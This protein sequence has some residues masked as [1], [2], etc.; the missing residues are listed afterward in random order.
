M[1][2]SGG[3]ASTAI[4]HG[5]RVTLQRISGHR[6]G[7]T[8]ACPGNAL[9]AQL[10]ELRRRAAGLAGPAAQQPPAGDARRRRRL[11]SPTARRAFSGVR[12]PG[13]RRGGSGRRRRGP[14]A[15]PGRLG[16]DRTDDDGRHGRLGRARPLAADRR[17]PRRGRG[18][19]LRLDG[20]HG[21][22][23]DQRPH[24]GPSRGLGDTGRAGRLRRAP[25]GHPIWV[26]IERQAPGRRWVR[27]GA[28]RL[29]SRGTAF[30]SDLGI[31]RPGLYRITAGADKGQDGAIVVR[32]VRRR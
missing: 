28:R 32:V 20:R 25:A 3:G 10:P 30:R 17:R 23:A 29:G 12:A 16:D 7:D 21:H 18:H 14:E 24:R 27:Y 9:Y 26:L 11:R 31:S 5:T 4:R 1:L 6:D 19:P 13:Q 8:T 2:V 22:P 15:R